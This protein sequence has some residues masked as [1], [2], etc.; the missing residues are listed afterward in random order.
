MLRV[1]VDTRSIGSAYKISGVGSSRAHRAH[2][3][4]SPAAG[5]RRARGCGWDARALP[6][7]GGLSGLK[8]GGREPGRAH[9]RADGRSGGCAVCAVPCGSPPPR[10]A[11]RPSS[12]ATPRRDPSVRWAAGC[13]TPESLHSRILLSSSDVHSRLSRSQGGSPPLCSKSLL[14]RGPG[15]PCGRRMLRPPESISCACSDP[16]PVSVFLRPSYPFAFPWPFA[17][18]LSSSLFFLLPAFLTHLFFF[19]IVHFYSGRF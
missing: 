9:R 7:S 13:S 11:R 4:G 8:G 15:E 10:P 6:V 19:L 1:F 5:K 2:L 16:K 14:R 17:F 3:A 12:G 18:L